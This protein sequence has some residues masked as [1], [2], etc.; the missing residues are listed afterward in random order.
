MCVC[1]SAAVTCLNGCCDVVSVVG[2]SSSSACRFLF[3]AASLVKH[4]GKRRAECVSF[5]LPVYILH[6]QALCIASSW[7]HM[8]TERLADS[9][10]T[11]GKGGGA[12]LLLTCG[13]ANQIPA[14]G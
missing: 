4:R 9:G 6:Q 11:T 2:C 12:L 13:H 7:Q 3:T 5:P 14:K 10:P 8:V 1:F